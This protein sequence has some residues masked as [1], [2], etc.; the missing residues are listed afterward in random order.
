M[1]L[2]GKTAE[3][4]RLV[5]HDRFHRGHLRAAQHQNH[6]GFLQMVVPGVLQAESKAG[7][8]AEA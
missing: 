4:R 1:P 6:I 8:A 7:S 5:L 3:Q 2:A